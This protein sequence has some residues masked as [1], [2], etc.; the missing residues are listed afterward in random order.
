MAILGI[1][2]G[3]L[4]VPMAGMVAAEAVATATAPVAHAGGCGSGG[5]PGIGG[6]GGCDY[7]VDGIHV[8]CGGGDGFGFGGGGCTKTY[9]DGRVEGCVIVNAFVHVD[10][11]RW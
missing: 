8:Q 11:C 1:A 7:W 2:A 5:V 6:G 3:V 4:G 9:P 10:T